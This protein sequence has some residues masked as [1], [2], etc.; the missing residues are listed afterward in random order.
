VLLCT[1]IQ[2]EV[3]EY[4]SIAREAVYYLYL[5]S[6]ERQDREYYSIAKCSDK[7]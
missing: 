7:A 2:R 4:H 5:Y 3:R 1:F 6:E